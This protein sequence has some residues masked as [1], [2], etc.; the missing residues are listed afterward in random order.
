MLCHMRNTRIQM[1]L[2]YMFSN[3]KKGTQLR[4]LHSHCQLFRRMYLYKT[5]LT[6]SPLGCLNSMTHQ[7]SFNSKLH[8][9]YY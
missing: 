3:L 5:F 6:E 1:I 8:L 2:L 9:N 7:A 4:V